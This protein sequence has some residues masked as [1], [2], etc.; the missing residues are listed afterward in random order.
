MNDHEKVLRL[1]EKWRARSTKAH[2]ADAMLIN[3]MIRELEESIAAIGERGEPWIPVAERLPKPNQQVWAS[4][5][6]AD[7]QVGQAYTIWDGDDW[8]LNVDSCGDLYAR[9]RAINVAEVT[10]WHALPTPPTH[11]PFA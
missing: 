10:H 3:K 11:E 2:P 5:K 4:F 7:G 9:K 6:W 1:R 8:F